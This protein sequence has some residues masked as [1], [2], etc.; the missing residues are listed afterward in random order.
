MGW[1]SGFTSVRRSRNF[2]FSWS[3]DWRMR[4]VEALSAGS[5]CDEWV[6]GSGC[7]FYLVERRGGRLYLLS[8][9]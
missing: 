7:S 3:R 9:S 2:L 4:D 5:Y 6:M 1:I 8:A